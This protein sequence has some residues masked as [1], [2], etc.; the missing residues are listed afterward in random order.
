MDSIPDTPP[1]RPGGGSAGGHEPPLSPPLDRRPRVLKHGELFALFDGH[2]DLSPAEEESGLYC[3]DTRHLSRLALTV[4]G[5]APVLLSS[6][7]SV[8]TGA[9]QADLT[10]PDIPDGAGPGLRRDTLHLRR[11]RV[12][13]ASGCFERIAVRN[14]AAETLAV[15]VDLAFDAD[16]HDIFEARGFRRTGRG[17]V[18]L[19][20]ADERTVR[21]AYD[22][23][24]GRARLT[25]L[26]FDP[27]PDLL[28]EHRARF[29]LSLASGARASVF[30]AV[31]CAA[32]DAPGALPPATRFFRAL[33]ASR[34]PARETARRAASVETSDAVAQEILD[35]ARA[36]LTM[37]TTDTASGA[38]P[39]AGVPWFSTAFGRD[40]L[41]TAWL[42][43]WA[44][45][46][47]TRGV[48]D[49]LA[50]LQS[51]DDDPETDAEPGKIVHET[52][53]G[54]LAAIGAV[55]FRRYYGAVDA[56]PLFVA[57][58]GAYLDRTGDRET[59]ARLAPALFRALDWVERYGD[60]DGDG[61]V[62]YARRR[63][64]GLL[65]QGWK[66][67][68]DSVFH[69]DGTLAEG[70]IALVEV[71]GYAL[72]AW[73]AGQRIAALL[74]EEERARRCRAA[75]DALAARIE[76]RF[77]DEALGTY[78]LALDG[79]K[80]PC[81]V[82]A[83]NAG[84]LLFSGAVRPERAARVAAQLM[85]PALFTGYG[86]RTVAAAEARY[87]PMSYHNGTVWPHDTALVALG[88]ARYGFKGAAVRLL[89]GML[90]AAAHME[91]RRL[92]ELFCGFRRTPGTGP[93]LYPVACAPQAWAAA[94]P[95]GLLAAALG[96]SFDAAAGTIR[97]E[98]PR[99]PRR[100]EE[101]RIRNLRLGSASVD[102]R[103]RRADDDV[104]VDAIDT[105]GDLR[106]TV[107]L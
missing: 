66:D 26:S 28:A 99:L 65:N 51:E 74:G 24:D 77:W 16:F 53:A 105:R 6:T 83:S 84:H 20:V 25:V 59:V 76:S 97:L 94:A 62:E 31:D 13:D 85:S 103:L 38:Y 9:F 92:P 22:G 71:Q 67:S 55:P 86:I 72:Q 32:A 41:L 61:L 64:D 21:F 46:A 27:A 5:R 11:T 88:L 73:R 34:R 106:V 14:F 17:A 79:D 69:A 95:F 90:E 3:R 60:L 81:R 87:N 49:Y 4:G 104:A 50:A 10:N 63:S 54:E 7:V 107:V 89:D 102:L 101:V 96:L 78:A 47:L 100:L 70:P 39:F 23:Q 52:R 43:L 80:R 48:L 98:R 68:D 15:D 2:G 75:A 36:D 19:A 37:L 58:A 8:A 18:R 1:A 35:R 29:R 56:T 33:R 57:L 44:D 45:P 42:T 91:L 30:L 40:G 93:T 82:R 12:L